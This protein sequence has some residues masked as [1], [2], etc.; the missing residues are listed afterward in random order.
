MANELRNEVTVEFGD[1]KVILRPTF[2]C[3]M[4]IENKAKKSLLTLIN[5]VANGTGT[6]SDTIIVLKEASKAGGNQLFD[7]DVQKLIE[8][9][10]LVTVQ[11]QLGA[12]FAKALY[13]GRQLE[14]NS[15]KKSSD[16]EQSELTGTDT[17]EQQ[18]EQS[19]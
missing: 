19:V 6:I 5:E 10:G 8:D 13:G 11:M 14:V 1:K 9:E 17:T 16:T 12:F 18:S 15:K 2:E 7:K 3:L 4:Q